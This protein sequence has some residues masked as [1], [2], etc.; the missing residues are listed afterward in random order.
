M[1]IAVANRYARALADVVAHT[2]DYR[3]ILRELE[4]F[5]AVYRENAELRDIFDTPA[6]PL[7]NKTKVLEVILA[8]LGTSK[9]AG[10]FLRVILSNYRMRQ[11]EEIV[12]VFLKIANQ[13]LGVV[14]VKVYSAEGLPETERRA[15]GSRF[16]EVTG[17]RV[18]VEFHQEA[19][20]LGGVLA[21]IESTVYDGSVRGHLQRIRQRLMGE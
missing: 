12:Q 17:K 16:E 1:A 10:N 14:Q 3:E 9:V 4:D 20:L 19:D 21:Q 6:V 2:G 13:Q 15:V 5:L 18:E 7:E 11:M 8:R